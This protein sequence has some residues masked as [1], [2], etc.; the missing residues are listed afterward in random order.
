[1]T[2]L[3]SFHVGC[4]LRTINMRNSVYF[5]RV[6]GSGAIVSNFLLRKV[7]KNWWHRRLACAEQ[8][9]AFD[10]SAFSGT[11]FQPVSNSSAGCARRVLAA[12][13]R[14]I[15]LLGKSSEH[16]R[17]P[18]SG[19]ESTAPPRAAAYIFMIYG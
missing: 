12:T 2:A 17:Y 3:K 9:K 10:K 13:G 5:W 19:R 1:M 8:D 14:P 18:P 6:E 11:G 7:L 15:G 4:A 16:A